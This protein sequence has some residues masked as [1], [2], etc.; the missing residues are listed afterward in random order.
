MASFGIRVSILLSLR[1]DLDKYNKRQVEEGEGD[2]SEGEEE[3]MPPAAN[4]FSHDPNLGKLPSI[5]SFFDKLSSLCCSRLY[6]YVYYHIQNTTSDVLSIIT[7]RCCKPKINH[8]RQHIMHLIFEIVLFIISFKDHVFELFDAGPAVIA[9]IFGIMRIYMLSSVLNVFSLL[10][11]FF[12][13]YHN[14]TRISY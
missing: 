7:N 5:L 1:H 8:T 10:Y 9:A 11:A 6:V 14:A 4:E 13:V 3:V 12:M 2:E